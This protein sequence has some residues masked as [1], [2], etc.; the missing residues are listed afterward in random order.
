MLVLTKSQIK[1]R[2]IMDYNNEA[3]ARLEICFNKKQ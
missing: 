2:L 1:T 3:F